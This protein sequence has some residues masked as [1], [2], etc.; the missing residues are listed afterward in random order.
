[1]ESL[2]LREQWEHCGKRVAHNYTFKLVKLTVHN[3]SKRSMHLQLREWQWSLTPMTA[4]EVFDL[5][6]IKQG[7]EFLHKSIT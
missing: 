7:C 6:Y 1:M 4:G 3:H 5:C 2:Q